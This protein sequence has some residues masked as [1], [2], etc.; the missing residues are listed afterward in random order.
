M[1]FL[2]YFSWNYSASSASM[3]TP[4]KMNDCDLSSSIRKILWHDN[5]KN[6]ITLYWS[7]HAGTKCPGP[8]FPRLIVEHPKAT[9]WVQIISVSM[10]YSF[11]SQEFHS[12]MHQLKDNNQNWVFLDLSDENRQQKK[13]FYNNSSTNLFHDNPSWQALDKSYFSNKRT[14]KAY[15]YALDDNGSKKLDR[16][17]VCIEWGFIQKKH[18]SVLTSLF[19]KKCSMKM[20]NLFKIKYQ[21]SKH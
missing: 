12:W 16:P 21:S 4:T 5:Y 10:P 19:P 13:P 8:G 20:W 3:L 2:I 17:L 14:W 1:C 15:L 18:S 7:N 6:L 9:N 11:V